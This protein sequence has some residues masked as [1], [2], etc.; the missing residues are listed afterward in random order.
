LLSWV[1]A[2]EWV[3]IRGNFPKGSAEKWIPYI[4]NAEHVIALRVE[5]ESMTAPMGKSYPSGCI[6]FVDTKRRSPVSGERVVAVE[7]GKPYATF[8]VYRKEEDRCWLEA[9]NPDKDAYPS[10]KE[11][12]RVIGTVVGK[13]EAE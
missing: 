6:I 4:E 9:R 1:Q 13:W 5:G 7:F 3:E 11:D 10:I 2:A 8:K 12:F